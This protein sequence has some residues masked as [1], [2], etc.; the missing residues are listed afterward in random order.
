[1]V[2]HFK[3]DALLDKLG[4]IALNADAVSW[5]L[6]PKDFKQAILT[7]IASATSLIYIAA[8]YVEDDEAGREVLHALLAAKDQNPQL[9]IKVLVDYHRARRGLIG[10]KG[11]SGNNVLYRQLMA[12]ATHPFD[13]VGVPVKSREFM[14]VLH[15]KGFIIDDT[16]IYSG[17]S[18]NNIYFQQQEKY[19][20]DRYHV[21]DSPELARSM[22]DMIQNDI[23]SD[24]AV[25]ILSQAGDNDD[26]PE[27]NDIK[28]F[29]YRLSQVRY[30]YTS[31]TV[32]NRVTPLVGL[33]RRNN[34]LNDT[35]I[36]LVDS[37]TQ[38]LFICTPYFNP[39]TIL[40]RA[41]A[42]HLREGKK[43]DIVVGDKTANDFYIP[44]DQDFTT[45]GALP[46]MY[47]QSLRKFAKNQQWAIDNG[48]LNIHLWKDGI[49]SFHLKGISADNRKHLI[50]GSNLNP[51]AWALDLENAL[52]LHDDSGCWKESFNKEQQYILLHTERLYHYSQIDT[53]QKYP[54]PVKKI[55]NRIRRLKADFLLRRIL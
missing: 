19:R 20:F 6:N 25:S 26:S 40:T 30:Q 48:Q 16:V 23:V 12:E 54:K 29:K 38:E 2:T 51:R 31:T 39:P 21:I 41:L 5:L 49:N 46:Y 52:L 8:L 43:I 34:V 37:S 44:P 53:L 24:P 47:E 33:G 1:M 32:G 36:K 4:G 15:L 50:T 18:I 55:M 45:I 13:I 28:S 42:R 9:E 7:K 14:G 35:I 22:R 11:D 17:A 27:K 10:Q 3:E